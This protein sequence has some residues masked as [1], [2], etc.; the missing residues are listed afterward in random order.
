MSTFKELLAAAPDGP[1]KI[2]ERMTGT[3]IAAGPGGIY[4]NAL[5]RKGCHPHHPTAEY[6]ARLNPEIMRLVMEALEA[7]EAG[8]DAALASLGIHPQR[9]KSK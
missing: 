4:L 1:W 2:S 9:K 7:S 3:A 5:V 6:I 8:S